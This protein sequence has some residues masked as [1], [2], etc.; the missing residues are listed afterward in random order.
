MRLEVN[1]IEE[2]MRMEKKLHGKMGFLLSDA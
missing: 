1:I 2:I